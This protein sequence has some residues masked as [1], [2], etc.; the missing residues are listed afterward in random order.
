MVQAALA[1][2]TTAGEM[3]GGGVASLS[4]RRL[5]RMAALAAVVF[6]VS[7]SVGVWC[8]MPAIDRSLE[9][10]LVRSEYCLFLG[11]AVQDYVHKYHQAPRTK[12]DL[13]KSDAAV[14]EMIEKRLRPDVYIDPR[15]SERWLRVGLRPGVGPARGVWV[16]REW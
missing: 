4:R 16:F 14:V 12:N 2:C 3:S 11:E 8:C 10:R 5:L 6:V 7:C 9:V 15:T 13:R 1:A